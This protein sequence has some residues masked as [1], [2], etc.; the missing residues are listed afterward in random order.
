MSDIFS[1]QFQFLYVNATDDQ[2]V[3]E[4]LKESLDT[5]VETAGGG[6]L[7]ASR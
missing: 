1:Q 2:R 4:P 5:G 7:P 3:E 6:A